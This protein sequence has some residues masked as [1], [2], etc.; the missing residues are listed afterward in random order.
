MGRFGSTQ[1]NA[2][3]KSYQDI[4]KGMVAIR[5]LA[6]KIVLRED[7]LVGLGLPIEYLAS[8][9]RAEIRKE[10][11]QKFVERRRTCFLQFTTVRPSIL[12]RFDKQRTIHT[13]QPRLCLICR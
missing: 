12:A 2:E 5:T 13:K 10:L 11:I 8:A 1:W 3:F 6:M 7:E 4:W 9:G